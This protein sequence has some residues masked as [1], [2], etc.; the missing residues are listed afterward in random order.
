MISQ[1]KKDL[2]PTDFEN[3]QGQEPRGPEQGLG[4]LEMSPMGGQPQQPDQ[5]PMAGMMQ[6]MNQQ[7]M[8]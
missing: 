3:G 7:N 2:P 1:R 8:L 4:G 6:Q 5:D